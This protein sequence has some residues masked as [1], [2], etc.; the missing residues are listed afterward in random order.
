LAKYAEANLNIYRRIEAVA[1]ID[2]KYRVLDLA[3]DKVRSA[4]QVAISAKS[5]YSADVAKDYVL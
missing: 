4:V 5:L 2:D 3:N 1:K